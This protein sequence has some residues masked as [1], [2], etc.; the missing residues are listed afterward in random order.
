MLLQAEFLDVICVNRYVGW[1]EKLG[2]I[3]QLNETIVEGV[4][5]W[6]NNYKKPFIVSEYGA[7]AILGLSEVI[8]YYN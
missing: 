3:E 2:L 6:K 1:Y 4:M 5:S 8:F 7:E